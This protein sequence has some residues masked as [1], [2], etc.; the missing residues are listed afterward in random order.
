MEN[1][2]TFNIEILET[3]LFA[4]EEIKMGNIYLVDCFVDL[5]EFCESFFLSFKIYLLK[6]VTA[7]DL[8]NRRATRMC[9]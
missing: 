8:S 9:V 6:T 3:Q 2:Y 4:L 5:S 1:K 7:R